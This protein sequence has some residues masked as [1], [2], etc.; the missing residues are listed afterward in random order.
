MEERQFSGR[1]HAQVI[2]V[3][4]G[5]SCDPLPHVEKK[6][7]YWVYAAPCER[8]SSPARWVEQGPFELRLKCC[9]CGSEYGIGLSL[10]AWQNMTYVFWCKSPV[11][12]SDLVQLPKETVS[13]IEA[14][15]Q[16]Q[17][18]EG[19]IEQPF[20]AVTVVAGVCEKT[21][22]CVSKDCPYRVGPRLT[23]KTKT[24]VISITS[25]KKR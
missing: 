9:K 23:K 17:E 11:F 5:E 22:V 15:I 3:G 10:A 16:K 18:L 6:T 14:I 24:N 19:P 12:R 8:C 7:K 2:F 4:I 21:L 13:K 20:L 25:I 1:G